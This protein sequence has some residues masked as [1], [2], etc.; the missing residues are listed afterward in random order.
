MAALAPSIGRVAIPDISPPNTLGEICAQYNVFGDVQGIL[1]PGD[2]GVRNSG[3]PVFSHVSTGTRINGT[4]WSLGM[5]S[6]EPLA[7]RVLL[8]EAPIERRGVRVLPLDLLADRTHLLN[9][10]VR[11]H[12]KSKT[13]TSCLW[14]FSGTVRCDSSSMSVPD[15]RWLDGWRAGP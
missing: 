12:L 8:L 2:T 9:N 6:Y 14:R 7:R 5:P 15:R 10:R 1:R 3:E 4:W 13:Q 11:S